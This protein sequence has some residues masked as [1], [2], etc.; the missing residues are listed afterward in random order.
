MR[1]RGFLGV[2]LDPNNLKQV[3]GLYWELSL[4]CMKTVSSA[5]SKV[6]L[7]VPFF[8]AGEAAA[9]WFYCFA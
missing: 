6:V 1:E 9:K 8:F 2:G 3:I 7:F 5:F 4:T